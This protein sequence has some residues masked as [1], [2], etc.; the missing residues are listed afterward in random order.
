MKKFVKIA[1]FAALTAL[2]AACNKGENINDAPASIP[3]GA[4]VLRVTIPDQLT[5][6]SF[7][8]LTAGEKG[9]A[10]AWQEGD[11]LRVISGEASEEYLIQDG[12]S[13]HDA[14]FAGLP[15]EGE[16][17]TIIYPRTM[18]VHFYNTCTTQATMMCS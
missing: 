1:A 13:A 14:E 11:A 8:D 7:T 4:A 3:D 10:L 9:V 16:S 17:Y 2:L 12:F 18:M 5:K 15:V 6:V